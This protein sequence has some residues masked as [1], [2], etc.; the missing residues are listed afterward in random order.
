MEKHIDFAHMLRWPF[1]LAWLMVLTIWCG[2]LMVPLWYPFSWESYSLALW[3]PQTPSLLMQVWCGYVVLLIFS[4]FATL[5]PHKQWYRQLA[6]KGQIPRRMLIA[7]ALAAGVLNMS[8]LE[9]LIIYRDIIRDNYFIK[10]QQLAP[11]EPLYRLVGIMLLSLIWG[12]LIAALLQRPSKMLFLYFRLL[13][14]L[15][16]IGLMVGPL[17]TNFI[18]HYSR[19]ALPNGV[20]VVPGFTAAQMMQTTVLIW[21]LGT[22]TLILFGIRA[23][24]R[25]NDNRCL[26]CGYDLQ[27]SLAHGD[28]TCP[29]CGHTVQQD[30]PTQ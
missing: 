13:A 16:S 7:T 24:F 22:S 1:L 3:F 29:E 23:A 10:A 18:A 27:G 26:A 9:V 30:R 17:G 20:S 15:L 28:G 5:S 2:V 8:V 6:S 25:F 19:Y 21:A 12:N 11:I 4:P 14:Y